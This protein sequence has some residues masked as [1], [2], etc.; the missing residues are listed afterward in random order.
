M[1]VLMVRSVTR[2]SLPEWSL[3]EIVLQLVLLEWFCSM[4]APVIGFGGLFLLPSFPSFAVL[5]DL[6]LYGSCIR[7]VLYDVISAFFFSHFVLEQ[8]N[9]VMLIVTCKIWVLKNC[10]LP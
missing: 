4:F 10:S 7:L 2:I 5:P 8:V 6:G 1:W 9:R 3:S